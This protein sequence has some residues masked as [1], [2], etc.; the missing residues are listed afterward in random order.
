[1]S[2]KC[3]DHFL[4]VSEPNGSVTV[5]DDNLD[6][7]AVFNG[8]PAEARAFVFDQL[9]EIDPE[10]DHEPI[11]EK[12]IERVAQKKPCK[13]CPFRRKAMPGW[14]GASNPEGFIGTMMMETE[15]LPCHST[16]DY[17][18][19]D[20]HERWTRSVDPRNKL[21]AGALTLMANHGK[22]PRTG[23][24]GVRDAVA[25]FAT[26]REF[27][28]HHRSAPVRSWT[29]PATGTV[30]RIGLDAVREYLK[31]PVLK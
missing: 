2:D 16:V 13:E 14:L 24:V 27:V 9:G 17:E 4:L 5:Y 15:P 31:L 28:E 12:P 23:P 3:I 25:V 21:C 18:R 1:M 19:P 10:I 30:A 8:S 7:E 20:W 29:D 26:Y 11:E 6:D 22:R